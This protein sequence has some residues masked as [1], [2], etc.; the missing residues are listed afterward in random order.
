MIEDLIS[1]IEVENQ[2]RNQTF[3]E[4]YKDQIDRLA[5]EFKNI[6]NF[7]M[8]GFYYKKLALLGPMNVDRLLELARFSM[9]WNNVDRTY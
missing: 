4:A 2:R 6:G 3:R 9:K 1:L 8:V 7:S 5:I